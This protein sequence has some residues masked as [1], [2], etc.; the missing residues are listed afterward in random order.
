MNT[1]QSYGQLFCMCEV[2]SLTLR[3][4]LKLSAQENIWTQE[5]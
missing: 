4:E 1:V 3:E 5:G 2:R